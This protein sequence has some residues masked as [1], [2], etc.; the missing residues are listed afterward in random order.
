LSAEA[1][2]KG[3]GWNLYQS[4]VITVEMP[5]SQTGIP[6]DAMRFYIR[7]FSI[8]LILMLPAYFLLFSRWPQ[9]S[10]F[11][12]YSLILKSFSEQLWAGELLPRWFFRNN[13]EFGSPIGLFNAPVPYYAAS[14]LQFLSTVDPNGFLRILIAMQAGIFLA[15]INCYRWLR[16]FFNTNKA[17][18][19][20][21]VYAG[22]P[23]ILIFIYLSF[24]MSHIWAIA[25]LPL[26]LK[27]AH[28]LPERDW[29]EV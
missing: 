10:D 14:M 17:Q 11:I 6:A 22:F 21:L 23:Y 19:G 25:L 7:L 13:Y 2:A 5:S 1:L 4:I 12:F 9:S 16:L 18:N 20:A 26:L 15:G 8:S 29:R 28:E 3:E 24:G 27:A